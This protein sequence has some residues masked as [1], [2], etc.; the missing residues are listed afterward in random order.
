MKA[1]LQLLFGVRIVFAQ[2]INDKVS[3]LAS[4]WLIAFP[5]ATTVMKEFILVSLIID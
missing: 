4:S 1:I 5:K 2:I 3:I